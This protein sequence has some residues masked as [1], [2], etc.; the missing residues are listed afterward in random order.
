MAAGAGAAAAARQPSSSSQPRFSSSIMNAS[1][2][3][4]A[5]VMSAGKAGTKLVGAAIIIVK[6]LL[7]AVRALEEGSSQLCRRL[8]GL[9]A[10]GGYHLVSGTLLGEGEWGRGGSGGAEQGGQ[11][12]ARSCQTILTA[13]AAFDLSRGLLCGLS[14]QPGGG[15]LCEEGH[16]EE[17]SLRE[18]VK[19]LCRRGARLNRSGAD[20]EPASSRHKEQR[21]RAHPSAGRPLLQAT[22]P[23]METKQP[24]PRA[25]PHT[26]QFHF[27]K[28][29]VSLA[30]QQERRPETPVKTR[31]GGPRAPLELDLVSC[32][33][34]GSKCCGA[35]QPVGRCAE[36]LAL[37][38]C[39]ACM[40]ATLLGR[41]QACRSVCVLCA[42]APAAS[43]FLHVHP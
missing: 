2:A 25:Q 24:R 4:K 11:Q 21:V 17:G 10:T 42:F 26:N 9:A 33:L 31:S 27:R 14:T 7:L 29:R 28:S 39:V 32:P 37:T 38:L 15:L 12:Q 22:V 35:A 6:R 16:K 8:R 13:L 36:S 19:G 20:N 34:T 5:A 41:R 40:V 23:P 1:K 3:A 30:G 43:V 18:Q